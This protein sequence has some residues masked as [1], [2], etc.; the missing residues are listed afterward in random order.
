MTLAGHT[1]S[2]EFAKVHDTS[3]GELWSIVEE[4]GRTITP[5]T[6]E[7]IAGFQP[8]ADE[9]IAKWETEKTADGIDAAGLVGAVGEL[10]QKNVKK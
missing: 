10:V 6:E 4:L 1:A 3:T 2:D 8:G 7:I 5:A 9:A